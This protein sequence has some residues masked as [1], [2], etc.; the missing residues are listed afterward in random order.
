MLFYGIISTLC[1]SSSGDRV[2][3]SECEGRRFD[4]CLAHQNG[5][6]KLSVFFICTVLAG[7]AKIRD[8]FSLPPLTRFTYQLYKA[9]G[10][11]VTS[12]TEEE[13]AQARFVTVFLDIYENSFN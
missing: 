10:W 3:H 11:Q 2:A 1:A 12:G 7:I 13:K 6:R 8:E 4:S 9:Y 5:Q